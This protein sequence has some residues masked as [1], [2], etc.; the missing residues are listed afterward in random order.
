MS[1]E[2]TINPNT[3]TSEAV[4]EKVARR[5]AA[6]AVEKRPVQQGLPLEPLQQAI[7]EPGKAV[8]PRART[9]A[10]QEYRSRYLDDIAP[11]SIVGRL[12]KFTKD[13]Q[14]VT[15]DDGEPIPA[16]TEFVALVDQTLVGWLKFNGD[17]EAPEREMGLLHDGFV[18]PPREIS[19]R[20]GPVAVGDRP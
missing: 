1:K 13:G 5:K 12:A 16:D 2:D 15:A 9:E 8:A 3:W 17:G 18:M 20:L 6:K 4:A 19:R 10:Q 14:F 7:R 11:A